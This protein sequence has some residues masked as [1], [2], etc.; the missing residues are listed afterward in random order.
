[1]NLRHGR[2]VLRFL[3]T[4][5]LSD[6]CFSFMSTLADAMRSMDVSRSP[7]SLTL[8]P[9]SSYHVPPAHVLVCFHS[10]FTCSLTCTSMD[11]RLVSLHFLIMSFSFCLVDS[12]AYVSRLCLSS[13]VLSTRLHAYLYCLRL[14][15]LVCRLVSRLII[16]GL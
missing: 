5:G 9:H 11:C 14:P 12:S 15:V 10:R 7:D 13:F 1:M 8:Y 6:S 2:E 16:Y 4:C 3:C